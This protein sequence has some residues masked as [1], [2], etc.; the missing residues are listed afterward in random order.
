MRETDRASL[1]RCRSQTG[2]AR[3]AELSGLLPLALALC[4][5]LRGGG[6][7]LGLLLLFTV[8]TINSAGLELRLSGVDS[9]AAT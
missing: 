8:L 4:F 6:L 7:L 5:A 9:V 3:G 2:R 1:L